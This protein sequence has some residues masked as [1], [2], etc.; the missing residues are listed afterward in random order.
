MALTGVQI[1]IKPK[2]YREAINGEVDYKAEC[3]EPVTKH[4]SRG[5]RSTGPVQLAN[6]LRD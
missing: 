3:L 2:L 5:D 6:P 4:C 1:S